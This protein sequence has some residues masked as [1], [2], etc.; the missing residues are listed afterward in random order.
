MTTVEDENVHTLSVNG[1]FD[2][3][4]DIVKLV[5]GDKEFNDKY[6]VGAVNSINWARIFGTTNIL[7]LFL[8]PITEAS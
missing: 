4:Q 8:F 7:F 5:F 3:C 2:D 6:H 1:T